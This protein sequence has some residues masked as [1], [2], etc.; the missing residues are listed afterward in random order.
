M[1]NYCTQRPADKFESLGPTTGLRLGAE[2]YLQYP[3]RLHGAAT[4]HSHHP[5]DVTRHMRLPWSRFAMRT[6]L[7]CGDPITQYSI[8]ASL[9]SHI[10]CPGEQQG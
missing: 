1:S 9:I 2:T 4:Q 6:F 10:V 5:T 8:L 7:V 3:L